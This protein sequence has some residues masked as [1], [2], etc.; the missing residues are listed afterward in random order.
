MIFQVLGIALPDKSS[1]QNSSFQST[2]VTLK[3][4]SQFAASLPALGSFRA[5]PYFLCTKSLFRKL[6]G[7]TLLLYLFSALHLYN[8]SLKWTSLMI[9]SARSKASFGILL[10][11]STK[12]IF[13]KDGSPTSTSIIASN[14]YERQK[15]VCPVVDYR[16]QRQ[17]HKMAGSSSAQLPLA[18]PTHFFNSHIMTLLVASVCPLLYGCSKEVALCLIPRLSR[19]FSTPLSIKYVLLGEIKVLGIPNWH[20]MFFQMNFRT[21]VAK[22]VA[23]G[24]AAI[25]MVK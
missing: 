8:L 10:F 20:T 7:L 13:E 5:S 25:H 12:C 18:F 16:E 23:M 21:L 15:G 1:N 11:S 22:M 2:S 9:F 17:A 4:P 6:L 14:P 24:S 3:S 19:N